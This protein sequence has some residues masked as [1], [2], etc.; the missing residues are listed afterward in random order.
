MSQINIAASYEAIAEFFAN[1]N[2]TDSAAYAVAVYAD[3]D[4]AEADFVAQLDHALPGWRKLT[5]SA[6]A[7]VAAVFVEA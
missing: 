6:A 7:I 3:S 2:P 1:S 5:C 4:S